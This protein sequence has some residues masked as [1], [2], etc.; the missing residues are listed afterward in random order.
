[1]K[2]F[3]STLPKPFFVQAPMEDATDT[4]FRQMIARCGRPDV[5][6]TE[7][8]SCDTLFSKGRDCALQRLKFSKIERPIVA[9]LWGN[10]PETYYKAVKLV[11]TMEF[12]AVDINMGCPDRNIVAN[13]F[14]SGLVNN[15]TLANDIIAAVKDAS[16]NGLPVSVKTRIGYSKIEVNDWIRFL[17]GQ[18]LDALTIHLRTS[19]ELSKVPAHWEEMEKIVE[20][21]NQISPGTILIG[22]GDIENI[23]QGKKMSSIYKFEGIMIGRA[24]LHN[25]W[26]FEGSDPSIYSRTERLELL[27]KHILLFKKTWGTTKRFQ[28]LK[29]YYKVYINGFRGSNA[30]RINLMDL[31]NMDETL[32]FIMKQAPDI[33]QPPS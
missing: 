7:F 27:Y 16:K 19:K 30:L 21:R 33:V 22:N 17:L 31:K 14:C 10:N 23:V 3:W 11:K 13:G 18:K 20:I 9:Q 32:N 1:M 12:D 26:I 29:K 6:F 4:V 15:H 2:N 8:T 24:M 28:I 25:P 5:F